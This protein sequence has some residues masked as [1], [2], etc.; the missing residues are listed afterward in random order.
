MADYYPLISKAIAS[1]DPDAPRETRRILYER[2]RG[3]QLVQLRTI[4]PLLSEAEITCERLALEEAVRRVEVEASHHARD[5]PTSSD[6]AMAADEIGKPA[7]M[8]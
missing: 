2:A 5:V 3:A 7:G 4:R 8:G 6:L 1:L